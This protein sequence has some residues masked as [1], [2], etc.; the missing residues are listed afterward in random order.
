MAIYLPSKTTGEWINF[1]GFLND[2]SSYSPFLGM[3]P[4]GYKKIGDLVY[5]RGVIF[6]PTSSNSE[7]ALI[8]PETIRP[9]R[10]YYFNYEFENTT[11]NSGRS[12]SDFSGVILASDGSLSFYS[13]NGS[14]RY[15]Q[16]D[17]INYAL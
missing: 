14:D 10:D 2:F 4:A 7:I 13:S 1:T 5:F 8:L 16:I 15:I 3:V 6:K 17:A 11:F 9:N 12:G